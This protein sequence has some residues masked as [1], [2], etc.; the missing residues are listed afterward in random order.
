MGSI[1]RSNCIIMS[2]RASE[3]KNNQRKSR[4]LKAFLK[5][6]RVCDDAV[7]AEWADDVERRLREVIAK[8]GTKTITFGYTIQRSKHCVTLCTVT[9]NLQT[10]QNMAAL[11]SGQWPGWSQIVEA[12]PEMVHSSTWFDAITNWEWSRKWDVEDEIGGL[13]LEHGLFE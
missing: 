13:R 7:K 8:I 9:P 2:G 4:F 1:Q 6:N 12:V 3:T 10:K 11:S 5:T